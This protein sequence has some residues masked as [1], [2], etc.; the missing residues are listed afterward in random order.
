MVARKDIRIVAPEGEAAFAKYFR[1]RYE[2]LRKPWGDVEGSERE[3]DDREAI[4]RMLVAGE[5]G[6]VIGVARLHF[7]NPDEAQIR[8]M[9]ICE[10]RRGQGLGR[11]LMAEMEA[12]ARAEGAKRVM[13]HARDYAVGFYEKLGYSTLEPSYLLMGQIQHYKMVKELK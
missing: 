13:L 10:E 5:E 3:D 2:T 6:T 7:N 9:A 4:H 12:V 1:L 8:L 11:Q